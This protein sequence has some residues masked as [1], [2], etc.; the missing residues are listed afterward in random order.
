MENPSLSD[1]VPVMPSAMASF[2]LLPARWSESMFHRSGSSTARSNQ[3]AARQEYACALTQRETFGAVVREDHLSRAV[4][5]LSG[6]PYPV[7]SLVPLSAWDRLRQV[8]G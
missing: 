8:G 5:R 3:P 7:H 1:T 2:A 4:S 6:V